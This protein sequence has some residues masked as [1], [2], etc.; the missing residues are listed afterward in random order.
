M[1]IRRRNSLPSELKGLEKKK[2][3]LPEELQN[4]YLQLFSDNKHY[5]TYGSVSWKSIRFLEKLLNHD[6]GKTEHYL[7]ELSIY[8][9][10]SN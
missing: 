4:F 5:T 2:K 7:V 6:L 1:E 8:L 3:H 10:T 9:I